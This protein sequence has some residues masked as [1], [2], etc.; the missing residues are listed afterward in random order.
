LPASVAGFQP[1]LA[2]GSFR[3]AEKKGLILR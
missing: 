2:F 3:T 1:A